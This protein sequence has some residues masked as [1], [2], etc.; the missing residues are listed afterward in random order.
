MPR[1]SVPPASD[2]LVLLWGSLA[3]GL[4]P[5]AA[6]FTD[7]VYK[8]STLPLREFEA[9][10]ITIARINDCTLCLDWRS[11]R[12]VPERATGGD[13]ETI[14]IDEAFYDSV[15]GDRAGL[16]DREALAA[17]FAERFALAHRDMDDEL[18]G[19]L[20]TAFSD[21]ELVELGLCVG[22]W[23]AFGRL[24]RVFDV[25]GGCRVPQR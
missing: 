20:H 17:E 9:A 7:A 21:S 11:A 19:R 15:L 14:V 23:I 2:P 3:P 18:W 1:I 13:G 16:S 12:D 5:T 8:R 24:N 4:T 6:A 10:R 22:S 25:D